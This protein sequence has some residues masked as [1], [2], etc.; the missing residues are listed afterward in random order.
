MDNYQK[1]VVAAMRRGKWFLQKY[2]QLIG[3]A[4]VKPAIKQL[5]E[6]IAGIL[7]DTTEKVE[8][9][10]LSLSGTVTKLD[11]RRRLLDAMT[12]V[13]VLA[14][15][16]L[17]GD[18]DVK[19]ARFDVPSPHASDVALIA[20]ARAMAASAAKYREKFTALGRPANFVEAIIGAADDLENKIV[21][22]DGNRVN[23]RRAVLG[24]DV[25][26][27]RARTMLRYLS[28]IVMGKLRAQPDL[29]GAWRQAIR[30]GG[31]PAPV[32]DEEG[33]PESATPAPALALVKD[34]Q[35][36]AA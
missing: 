8:S 15:G 10:K 24:I 27:A 17:V 7:A 14:L 6:G 18:P 13:S 1:R 3:E 28:S 20:G 35:Q 16:R 30:I 12:P 31:H 5:E 4:E 11:L 21:E 22:R 36:K 2:L 32:P 19:L 26:L 9:N 34:D 33:A 29:V 25:K 23:R